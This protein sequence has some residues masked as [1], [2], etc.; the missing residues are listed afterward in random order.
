MK[1]SGPVKCKKKHCNHRNFLYNG[2]YREHCILHSRLRRQGY[3]ERNICMK[4]FITYVP[5][6]TPGRLQKGVYQA[7]NNP[8]LQVDQPL[9]FPVSAIINGYAEADE[10]ICVIAI[11]E[12]GNPDCRSNLDLMKQEIGTIAGKKGFRVSYELIEASKDERVE[13]QLETYSSLISLMNDGDRLF[14]CITYGTKPI[15]IVEFMALHFAYRTRKNVMVECLAYGK[16][17]WRGGSAGSFYIYD[18]TALF[19]M[20]ELSGL[21]AKSG[22]KDPAKA[23]KE[24]LKLGD[25]NAQ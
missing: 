17:N 12:E 1:R 13:S 8:R 18:V 23:I 15:P 11:L 19:F 16:I 10:E 3:E 4:K 22:S 14:A 2:K 7:D 24:I 21:L 6:Q 25:G 9:Q 20:N 5:M